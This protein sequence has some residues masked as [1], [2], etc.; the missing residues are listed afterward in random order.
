[1]TCRY[2]R[3]I[4]MAQRSLGLD[5][6]TYRDFLESVTGK[7]STTAMTVKQRWR[8]VEALKD[9]GMRFESTKGGRPDVAKD[10]APQSRLIRHLWLKLKGMGVLRDPSERALLAYVKGMTGKPCMEWCRPDQLSTV[11]EALKKWVARIEAERAAVGK[12]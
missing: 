5:D 11:I 7:R 2:Q 12:A 8:V 9:K 3:F 10:D 4:K 1:M 6:D